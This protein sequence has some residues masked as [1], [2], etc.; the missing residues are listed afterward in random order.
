MVKKNL[1]V[2]ILTIIFLS[3][4]QSKM[5]LYDKYIHG[6]VIVSEIGLNFKNFNLIIYYYDENKFLID[7]KDA[8]LYRLNQY[9]VPL[10]DG[11]KFFRFG[12]R[13]FSNPDDDLKYFVARKDVLKRIEDKDIIEHDIYITSPMKMHVRS[14]ALEWKMQKGIDEYGIR[15]SNAKSFIDVFVKD[16]NRLEY[17]LLN[18][19]IANNVIS[20]HNVE[21]IENNGIE[22][23][24]KY[25]NFLIAGFVVDDGSYHQAT[26]HAERKT[27]DGGD[28]R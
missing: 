22:E 7:K 3:S 14:N 5:K 11:A 25:N 1:L 27:H 10:H 15:I 24:D 28:T 23:I 4:C 8:D 21:I 20:S 6:K 26:V 18:N 9:I 19:M 16:I 12:I 17:S 2:L 13:N